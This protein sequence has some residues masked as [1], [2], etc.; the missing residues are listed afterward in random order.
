MPSSLASAAL[1]MGLVGGPHCVAMCGAGCAG[2]IR[3][4]R[5]GAPA[6]VADAAPARRGAVRAAAF[7]LGRIASYAVAGAATATATQGLAF[8]SAQVAALRPLWIMFHACVLAWGALLMLHGRQPLWAHRIGRTVGG[9]L[10][11]WTASTA[12]V[13][14]TGALWVLMPCGLLYSALLVASLADTA[15][16]GAVT[17]ALFALGGAISLIAAPWLWQRLR[18]HVGRLRVDWANRLAGLVLSIIAAQALRMDIT[19]QLDIY[20]R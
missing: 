1:L 13:L 8:A 14:A 16:Q 19:Q 20:C 6:A 9:R 12:G 17:M 5:A 11:P 3:L 2:V 4:V 7:H 18:W 15:W 10:Q